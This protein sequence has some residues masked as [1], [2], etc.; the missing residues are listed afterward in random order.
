MARGVSG[1]LSIMEIATG[2]KNRRFVSPT[3]S[4][5]KHCIA[6]EKFSCFFFGGNVANR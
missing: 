4:V 2:I 6:R 3:L 5:A 1:G